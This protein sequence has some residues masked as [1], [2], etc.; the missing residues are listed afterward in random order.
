L[1]LLANRYNDGGPFELAVVEGKK[2]IEL[3]PN[4]ARP[5]VNV[6]VAYIE[7]NKFDEAKKVLLKA[8]QL[9]RETTNMHARSL[10]A[11]LS[12]WATAR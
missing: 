11:W 10:P 12:C 4:D 7:L 8:Q 9:G 6:G 3:N 1:N 5:Y 2:A